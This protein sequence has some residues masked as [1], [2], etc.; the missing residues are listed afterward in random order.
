V[1]IILITHPLLPRNA[2]ARRD[3]S[4]AL[5]PFKDEGMFSLPPPSIDM[6]LS[7]TTIT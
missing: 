5:L 7:Q 4:S 2:E 1:S 3:D 6:A